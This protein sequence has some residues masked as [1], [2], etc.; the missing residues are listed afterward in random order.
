MSE[1]N[2]NNERKSDI[3][4]LS[5]L[6][7]HIIAMVLMLCDHLWATIVPGANWLT[8][9]GRLAFP[10]YAFLITEG[11]FHTHNLKK[12]M[13]RLLIF[14]V[15]SEVPFNLLTGGYWINPFQQN[16]IWT[17]LLGLCC[18][19]LIE[20]VKKKGKLW[21]T[22]LMSIVISLIGTIIGF[23]TSVDYF[24][25]GVLTVLLFYFLHGRKWW[26]MAGQLAG[27]FIINGLLI[28]GMVVPVEVFGMQFEIS[29][30]AT[31]VLALIPI[32]LYK[33]KQGPHNRV[34]QLLC[35]GFYP[36]HMLILSLIWLA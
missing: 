21:L 31:A 27:L 4:G 24:G 23:I 15:V 22:I 13:L 35:Y 36:L 5:S 2:E 26:Q 25:Y 14:A 12:Y 16:V 20:K 1:L 6:A 33:G 17:L 34:I 11:F 18:I 19:S 32:W 9:V 7:L 29:Q 28:K 3:K 10:I 8:W 30:Q